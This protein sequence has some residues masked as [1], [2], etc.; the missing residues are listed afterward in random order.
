VT[1]T[2]DQQAQTAGAG[3]QPIAYG[4]VQPAVPQADLAVIAQHMFALMFRN[5]ASDGYA[6]ADPTDPSQFSRPGCIIASTGFEKSVANL[7][8]SYAAF[9]SAVRT[10]TVVQG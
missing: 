8:W 1:P 6:F 3:R 5:V 9:L 4:T 2:G 10:R 7:T